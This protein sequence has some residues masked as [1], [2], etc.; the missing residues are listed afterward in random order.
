MTRADFVRAVTLLFAI[1]GAVCLRAAADDPQSAADPYPLGLQTSVLERDLTSKDYADVLATMIPTDLAAEWKRVATPD[2]YAVFLKEHGG[3]ERVLADP[4]LKAAY[5]RRE[6]VANR[7]LELMRGA[8][9]KRG[10]V[11]PF[12]NGEQLDLLSAAATGAA[13]APVQEVPLRA[14]LTGPAAERNWPGLR[15]PTG[16]GH[17]VD[18]AQP[19]LT[20]SDSENI[21]WKTELPGNGNSS[22]VIWENCLFTTCASEDGK[23]RSL[24]CHARDTGKL[25]W[26]TAIPPLHADAAEKLYW[27][28]TYASA[29]PV[30]D[31]ER[32]FAFLGNDGLV[33]CD[34]TGKL[35]WQKDLGVFTTTH[36]PGAS[37]VLHKHKV[38]MIQ[39]QNKGDSVCAAF[40]KQS[41]EK[42]WEK[43]RD[44]AMCWT[45]PLL[46]RVGDHDELIH[47]GSQ[48]VVAYDPENGE[49]LW[50]VNGSSTESIPMAITGGGLIYSMSGRN[51]PMLAIRPGGQGDV[52]ATHIRWQIPRGGPHVP[53]PIYF[54]DLF[55][56]NDTGIASCL[57]AQTGETIWQTRLRGRFSMSPVE[58]NGHLLFTSETGTTYVVKAGP[59]YDLVATNE[60]QE[61]VLATPA[62]LGGRIYFRT[63]ANLICVG[64]LE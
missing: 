55:L 11:P 20:W 23:R 59:K 35:Q 29:T 19:P 7:F 9:K 26:N 57:S 13:A 12:D 41:G 61:D 58:T 48:T 15:G 53:S 63:K 39:D 28:N 32:V 31:G 54:G 51:G 30:T 37:P 18:G 56:V 17:A 50:W 45:T 6:R 22:P 40:D 2:N 14:V 42:L 62:V 43:P 10:Q 4:R 64:K 33:C 24:C 49:R 27:K 8:Y 5:E 52:T 3:K 44:K 38:I 25:V 47:N 46:V 36:G 21:L 34:F 60:L 16:Q 1:A